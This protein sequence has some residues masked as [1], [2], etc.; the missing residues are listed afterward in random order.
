MKNNQIILQGIT[1]EELLSEFRLIIR[2]EV[3]KHISQKTNLEFQNPDDW[4][5]V[6]QA[7][8]FLKKAEQTIY[9]LCSSK[10]LPN[11]KKHGKLYFKRSELLEWIESGRN[12]VKR[13]SKA[14]PIFSHK[15]KVK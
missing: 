12:T 8:K 11:Y 13:K 2:E 10:S 9:Q 3:D 4:L 6:S 7:S 5:D 1:T 15:P 14:I